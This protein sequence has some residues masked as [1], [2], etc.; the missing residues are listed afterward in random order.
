[1]VVA[2]VS[3]IGGGRGRAAASH[4]ICESLKPRYSPA[5][6][7][8]ALKDYHD[9]THYGRF[10]PSILLLLCYILHTSPAAWDRAQNIILS[11][12][13]I[14]LYNCGVWCHLLIPLLVLSVASRAGNE[15][16]RSFQNLL[17]L[18][19]SP[20]LLSHLRIY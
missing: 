4:H 20:L 9:K 1:M 3:I 7:S 15:H 18:G 5:E 6:F 16:L 17:L 8:Q 13:F 11:I 10:L 19:P 12:I 14:E 2:G